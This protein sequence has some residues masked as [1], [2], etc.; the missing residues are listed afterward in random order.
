M[1]QMG[2]G[3]LKHIKFDAV[4]TTARK[5]GKSPHTENKTNCTK[6]GSYRCGNLRED[7]SLEFGSHQHTGPGNIKN[8]FH[9]K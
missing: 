5:F 7:H 9:S 6:D 4:N 3:L 2:I 8:I 1:R